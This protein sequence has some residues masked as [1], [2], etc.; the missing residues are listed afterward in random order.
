MRAPSPE[1]FLRLIA[2]LAAALGGCQTAGTSP[3]NSNLRIGSRLSTGSSA[4]VRADAS[5]PA[6]NT[7]E[8]ATARVEVGVD[9]GDG[10]AAA[11]AT[12]DN[13]KNSAH[14]HVAD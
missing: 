9:P 11:S 5:Q 10:P 3:D 14:S 13:S 2:I 6:N 8:P 4:T 7:V 1:R 12:E